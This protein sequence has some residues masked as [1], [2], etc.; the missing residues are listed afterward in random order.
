MGF[1]T[2]RGIDPETGKI[3]AKTVTREKYSEHTQ[4][5][6]EGFQRWSD[7][8]FLRNIEEI[9]TMSRTFTSTPSTVQQTYVLPIVMKYSSI[10]IRA[11]KLNSST[12]EYELTNDFSG[13]ISVSIN[14]I[15]HDAT[16]TETYEDIITPSGIGVIKFNAVW[17]Y[18]VDITIKSD[19]SEV[20][21]YIFDIHGERSYDMDANITNI[22]E[23]T[24][25]PTEC[26]ASITADAIIE[27][28]ADYPLEL[29]WFSETNRSLQ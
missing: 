4:S 18:S 28:T 24:P 23:S 17:V 1:V 20:G 27:A 26:V 12:N 7:D 3:K 5:P 10:L 22:K 19:G 14:T 8:V 6:T 13:D 2:I 15:N 9:F 29:I 21:S 16:I 25:L 11:W